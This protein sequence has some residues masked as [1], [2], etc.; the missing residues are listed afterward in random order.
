MVYWA[1]RRDTISNINSLGLTFG[2]V[3][4][5]TSVFLPAMKRL[6]P[7][8]RY[9][10]LWRDFNETV[11][12]ACRW[13]WYSTM[14]RNKEGRIYPGDSIK[15]VRMACAWYWIELYQYLLRHLRGCQFICFPFDWIKKRDYDS[16]QKIFEFCK[17]GVPEKRLIEDVLMQ[18]YNAARNQQQVPK[19]WHEY[20][21]Q[22]RKI[23]DILI[24]QPIFTQKC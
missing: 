12:S 19:I 7:K 23:Q 1:S 18:K 2:E 4:H 21:D 17:V 11:I 6:F 14:D 3:N 22:A 24:S 9:I 16:I 8:A 10:L 5:R 15:D 13:G 20:D